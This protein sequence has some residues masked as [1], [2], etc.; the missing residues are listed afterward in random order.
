M[1][2]R[3]EQYLGTWVPGYPCVTRPRHGEMVG[4]ARV[5][6]HSRDT[7]GTALINYPR[8]RPGPLQTQCYDTPP[9]HHI[10][11]SLRDPSLL[12]PTLGCGMFSVTKL[13]HLAQQQQIYLAD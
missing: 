12:S 9:L 13:S 10:H 1:R 3:V 2:G 5:T 4:S 6:Q 8:P 11:H 7:A